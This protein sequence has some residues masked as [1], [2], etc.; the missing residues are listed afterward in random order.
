MLP[1]R[2]TVLLLLGGLV[3]PAMARSAESGR[4]SD[5]PSYGHDLA[6][7]RSS[8]NAGAINARSVPRLRVAWASR[9]QG[10]DAAGNAP[11]VTATPAVQGR[12]AV[13]GDWRGTVHA[14]DVRSGAVRWVTHLAG[15]QYLAQINSSPAIAGNRVFVST[16]TGHVVALDRATGRQRWST[17][18][19]DAPETDLFSS[20]TVV[21]STV[22][23]GVSSVQVALRLSPYTFHGSVVALDTRSGRI[24]W[25]TWVQRPGIDGPGGSVWSSAAADPARGLLY[26][27]TGQAYEQPAGP[28][29]D[30]LLALRIRDGQVRWVRQFTSGDAFNFFDQI[31]GRDYDIGASPNLFD[32]Y[33]R[34]VVGVGDKGGHYAVFDASTG[35]T[36]WHRR[37]CPGSHLGGIMT[38]AAVARGSIWATCNRLYD[39]NEL[40]DLANRTSI[41]RL[42]AAT[43]RTLWVRTVPGGTA[44]AVTEAG[45]TVFVPNTLGTVRA[46]DERTGRLLWRV[47]PGGPG[48]S[49]DHGVAGASRSRR[50]ASSSHTAIPSSRHLPSRRTPSADSS[51][52]AFAEPATSAGRAGGRGSVDV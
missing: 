50:I 23:I 41:M 42:D 14:V 52:T 46:F 17:L 1:A 10:L 12:L 8:P 26:I 30:S 11:F 4:G 24:R 19:D 49:V 43:G 3:L 36:V 13:W 35:A 37:L 15:P 18:V 7:S 25:R 47:R 20:P 27:G 16:G 6:N 32:I 39:K 34:R 5:W 29:T 33:G 51:H 2:L 31:R 48:S 45:G 28:R 44:G 40:A 38:T 21:G 22:V 9:G